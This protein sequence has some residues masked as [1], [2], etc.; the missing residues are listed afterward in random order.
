[1]LTH[2]SIKDFAIVDDLSLD[3]TQGMTVLTG[4]TGA[5]KS[6]L[7]DALNYALGARADAGMVRHGCLR[8]DIS[9][10]FSLTQIP[11]ARAWLLEADLLSEEECVLRRTIQAD[12]KSKHF[13][14]GQLATQA[15][16]RSLS[17]ALINI[18]GQHENQRLLNR[19]EQQKL[20]DNFAHHNDLLKAVKTH[21][22]TWWT[23][24][25]QI[26]D[27]KKR[28][29][30]DSELALRQYQVEELRKLATT[31]EEEANLTI[32]Y[33][34][35]NQAESL[36]KDCEA[37]NQ[38]LA[39][40]E[41]GNAIDLLGTTL[42]NIQALQSI[43]PAFT[44]VYR[45]LEEAQIQA[46]EAKSEL[47]LLSQGIEINPERL[48]EMEARLTLLN[49]TAR[50]YKVPAKELASLQTRLETELNTLAEADN[51]LIILEKS[52]VEEAQ[53]YNKAA[54]QLSK[55]RQKAAAIFN[56]QITEHIQNLGMPQGIF[57]LQFEK[58]EKFASGG[59]EKVEFLISPNPGQPLKPLHK[60]ASG[61]EL[62]RISLAIHVITAQVDNTPC[63]VFDEVDV[64][65]S[66]GTAEI[67]GRLLRQLAQKTQVICITHLAQVAAQGNQ[68]LKI[69][70]TV[71]AGQTRSHITELNQ[72]EQ[73]EEI[74]RLL[75][76]VNITTKTREHAKEMLE[77]F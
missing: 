18:H 37:A 12:G 68:H 56:T 3:L 55:S 17:A 62:S 14:N 16:I 49:E 42:K 43:D 39:D 65:I 58:L 50:K 21:Y 36:I 45:L 31:P 73:I 7:I 8:A 2:I 30:A 38:A 52:L 11:E 35:L 48:R 71:E 33:K 76:G 72:V 25:A 40:N 34:K 51:Y 64:G 10:A 24:S 20:L 67:V 27:L 26:T 54:A 47:A 53:A 5:G 66:G 13:I 46:Q 69:S 70:K 32:E 6:I 74:A 41:A 15:Q 60:I 22:Q 59:V 29:S 1:M 63:L 44:K 9:V 61:G 4:E 57:S 77:K 75:G 19:D 28:S 23:T